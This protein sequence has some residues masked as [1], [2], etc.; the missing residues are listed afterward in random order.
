MTRRSLAT[1]ALLALTLFPLRPAHAAMDVTPFIGAM[2]PAKTQF[3]DGTGAAYFRMQTHTV[4]G[5]TL[6]SSLSDKLGME[7]V[8]GTG[9]GKLE[10]VG[11]STAIELASTIYLADLRGRLR[12]LGDSQSSL[13]GVV[14]VGYTD[15]A[16]GLFDLAEETELGTFIGRVTG[17]VG[18][19][20]QNSFSDRV[21]LNVTMVDR[22]HA[23]G[24][25]LDSFGGEPI[26]K[27]QNDITITAGLT[28]GI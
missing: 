5:L 22:I 28:F 17:V 3:M 14:G 12:L 4:Y 20:I 11:G 16:V 15:F 1:V 2:I 25:A 23:S 8:L 18:A 27:T 26:K 9:T 10:L 6:G 7:V 13:S 21:R 19:E 24:I